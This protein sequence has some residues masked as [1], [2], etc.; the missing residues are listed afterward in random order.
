MTL[1][2]VAP[3]YKTSCLTFW[4]L[5]NGNL[6]PQ[7]A[8]FWVQETK[9][10][11]FVKHAGGYYRSKTIRCFSIQLSHCV[12]GHDSRFSVCCFVLNVLLWSRCSQRSSFRAR[13]AASASGGS[14]TVSAMRKTCIS[15]NTSRCVNHAIYE[16]MTFS[17]ADSVFVTKRRNTKHF[18]PTA[19]KGAAR[20][21]LRVGEVRPGFLPVFVVY[22][23]A[24]E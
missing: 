19:H 16:Y 23:L 12:Q 4:C 18:A 7:E 2:Q 8:P 10:E 17:W 20:S 14:S 15:T 1:V 5:G 9:P 22:V 3:K 24:L 11:E 13:S 6:E 21:F